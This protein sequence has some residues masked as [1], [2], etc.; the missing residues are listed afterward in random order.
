MNGTSLGTCLRVRVARLA[1]VVI[2]A[3]PVAVASSLS[4]FA[5]SPEGDGLGALRARLDQPDLLA[6]CGNTADE[7]AAAALEDACI[8]LETAQ[9]ELRAIILDLQRH[10]A[11]L[12]QRESATATAEAAINTQL[13]ELVARRRALEDDRAALEEER[14]ALDARTAA[15]AE[16][17]A[18]AKASLQTATTA[19]LPD[20]TPA[21]DAEIDPSATAVPPE[22]PQS[23]RALI[24]L[25]ESPLVVTPSSRGTATSEALEHFRTGLE[26][27]DNNDLEGAITA[28]RAAA[29]RGHGLSAWRIG[30]LLDPTKDDAASH[31]QL[32]DEPLNALRWY[33]VAERQNVAAAP[34]DARALKA[35]ARQAAA[36]GQTQAANMLQIAEA[37]GL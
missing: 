24:D 8:A 30:T 9:A 3:A 2:L 32:L 17:E 16:A 7:A 37:E 14:S 33:R 13:S 36:N 6:A 26:A 5:Q 34:R 31:G 28:F 21:A 29:E 22:T 10:A 27:L 15:L 23:L 4:T 18:A 19:A 25:S 12:D 35:W 1:T 11:E 20:E